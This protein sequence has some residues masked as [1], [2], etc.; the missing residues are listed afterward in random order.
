MLKF[1]I[2]AVAAAAL[3]VA[4]TQ[5]VKADSG[6][7]IAGAIVGGAIVGIIAN[8]QA[9]KKRQ[10]E[11]VRVERVEKRTVV[12]DPAPV[13]D[14]AR[15]ETRRVQTALNY[16]SFPAGPADG[17][18]GEQTRTGVSTYQAYMNYP[19]TGTLTNFEK[20]VLVKAYNEAQSPDDET[21]RV[22]AQ[23]PDG[24]RALLQ[25]KE[26]DIAQGS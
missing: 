23:S 16:F 9:K 22:I 13:Y 3:S 21:L 20:D 7:A 1:T 24:R 6:D 18:R 14:P 10:R 12:V 2:P 5:P 25:H 8:E 17:V 4:P 19:V 11:A 26:D 15:A